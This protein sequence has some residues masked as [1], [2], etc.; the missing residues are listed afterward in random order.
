MANYTR[1]TTL[2]K[3]KK[4]RCFNRAHDRSDSQI[5]D[6]ILVNKIIDLY[7]DPDEILA[8]QRATP[9]D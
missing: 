9:N 2:S 3:A 7:R 4:P 6:R 5:L 1:S 8:L